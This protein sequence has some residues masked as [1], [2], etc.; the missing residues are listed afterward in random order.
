MDSFTF[1][2]ADQ[3]WELDEICQLNHQTFSEE[4][5][6]HEKTANGF[7][8]DKFHSENQYIICINENEI[9]GMAALRDVRPFSL[10]YKL[11][12]LDD[13]LPMNSS[14]CE[15]RLLIIKPKYRNSYVILYLFK[16]MFEY[17]IKKKY[18]L[19][20]ISGILAQQ[21]F[22]RNFGFVPFGPLVGG[23]VKF[24]PMYST[25]GFFFKSRHYLKAVKIKLKNINALP[26]PVTVKDIVL[27]E[28][29]KLSV[30][31]RSE[32]FFQNY[33]KISKSLCQLANAKEVQIFTGSATLANEVMISHLKA[34]GEKGLI[35]SNGEFGNRIIHQAICQKICFT[36]YKVAFGEE[37][38]ICHFEQLLSMEPEIK[39]VFAV[40]CETSSGVLNDIVKITQICNSLNIKVLY[41]CVSTFGI[42]PLNLEKV[43]M[44][45]VSSGKAIGSYSGLSLIFFNSLLHIPED[46][47]PLYL[48]I[49]HYIRKNGM[50]F[51]MNSNSL[52]ALGTAV[53]SID[54]NLK[55]KNIKEKSSWLRNQVIDLNYD[56]ISLKSNA[57]HPAII[58]IRLPQSI[59]STA[60]GKYLA[61]HNITI[62]YGSDYLVRQNLIQICLFSEITNDDL[63]YIVNILSQAAKH[64]EQ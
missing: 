17:C 45:S 62:S 59:S 39:W 24:Q 52:Y 1:K 4:I 33:K 11:T 60:F 54:I 23:E 27:E 30:S 29:G 48:D 63:I 26:G 31:H 38:D 12:N 9:V 6:Q 36:E 61:Q 43:Y 44:A 18:D 3:Q 22:Y 5:P 58:T 50:P 37:F 28:F 55:Y 21:K 57:L 34:I 20:V 14:M 46:S 15:I 51:T 25:P 41:D 64:F 56:V 7:L 47:V 53:G 32:D 35:L 49:W 16:E 40:H 13:Y 42:I 8:V 2:I 10:D 19:V